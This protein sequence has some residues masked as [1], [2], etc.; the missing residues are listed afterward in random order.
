MQIHMPIVR[1]ANEMEV[2]SKHYII[3]WSRQWPSYNWLW[4]IILRDSFRQPA[5]G[6]TSFHGSQAL[7]LGQ[8]HYFYMKLTV[9]TFPLNEWISIDMV[10]L[11]CWAT[12]FQWQQNRLGR[13]FL[14]FMYSGKAQIEGI[15]L[16]EGVG[17]EGKA[18]GPGTKVKWTLRSW[19]FSLMWRMKPTSSDSP[20][21]LL[22]GGPIV[23]LG[24]I[25]ER[26]VPS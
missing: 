9:S 18:Q 17:F 26:V 11:P 20:L 2:S 12:L 10:F 4:V 16:F 22:W 5:N 19:H 8:M 6:A 25:V 24:L 3:E 14:E 7:V 23:A 1:G 21:V 13:A 15:L